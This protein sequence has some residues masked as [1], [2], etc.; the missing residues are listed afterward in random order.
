LARVL[1]L[2]HGMP[3][4]AGSPVV[5]QGLRAYANGQGL[6]S[7]GHEVLYCTRTEDLPAALADAPSGGT[8]QAKTKGSQAAK[9]RAASTQPLA[10]LGGVLGCSGNPYS[11]TET[12][13]LQAIINEVAPDVILV[14]SPEDVRRL[15]SG[16]F[17][18][19]L[20]LYAPRI[21]EAQYQDGTEER[22]AVRLFDAISRADHFIFSNERQRHFFLPLLALSGVDCTRAHGDVV[23]ISCPPTLPKRSATATKSGTASGVKFLAGGVFWPW[24]DLSDGL[25]ELIQILDKA[26]DGSVQLFGGKYGIRSETTRYLDPRNK[27]PASDRLEF[28]GIVPI[29]ELWDAYAGGSVAFD[30]MATGAERSINLS[31]RQI[32]YLR[33]GLPIITSPG[34]VIAADL[35]QYGAGWCV[36]PDDGAAL[37]TLVLRLLSEPKLIAKAS[38]NAQRLAAEKYAWTKTIAPLHRFVSDPR[39]KA[40][41]ETFLA[42]ITREQ[43]DLWEDREANKELRTR[44]ARFSSDLDKKTAEL[45]ARNRSAEEELGYWERERRT[46]RDES[47]EAIEFARVEKQAALIERDELKGTT[48]T[49]TAQVSLLQADVR[50][51]TQA[52]LKAQHAREALQSADAVRTQEIWAQANREVKKATRERGLAAEQEALAQARVEELEAELTAA[53]T[54][55]FKGQAERER[56]Q[57][58]TERRTQ[59]V[60]TQANSEVLKAQSET[61]DTED[62]LV[63]AKVRI[64]ELDTEVTGSKDNLFE[65][66]AQRERLREDSER[67]VQHVWTQANSEVLKAQ[68]ETSDVEDH[69]VKAQARM[70][71]LEDDVRRKTEALM[72]AE[73]ERERVQ[74]ESDQHLQEVW[75]TANAQTLAAQS[76]TQ[77]VRNELALR[78]ARIEE[79]EGELKAKAEALSASQQ[80]RDSAQQKAAQRIEGIWAEAEH[81]VSN[82]EQRFVEG[83][84]LAEERATNFLR[85]AEATALATSD[86]ILGEQGNITAQV[87][88][89]KFEVSVLGKEVKKKSRE[90]EEAQAQRD[91]ANLEKAA[92]ERFVAKESAP[93]PVPVIIGKESEVPEA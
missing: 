7:E 34:Q 65:S 5:G 24:A 49:L 33:C 73:R 51:K 75:R 50:K 54:A 84:A 22:D 53:K 69:L 17:A 6:S 76:E 89:L 16:D 19:V 62:R 38:K 41:S 43:A 77:D 52:L 86:V 35:L 28:S 23:P 3:P 1:I 2:F 9:A 46:L 58:E 88:E 12:P 85:E 14:E 29:D 60:W 32:D 36:D 91:A 78:L 30:L 37:R 10:T 26:K 93:E 72:T 56:L 92:L 48:D 63:Q 27:L 81:R 11:F 68:S 71:E 4:H 47:A 13:Q 15:P 45:A 87:E 18:V 67:R 42:R 64:E 61:S 66:Q 80:E 39:R 20:D 79:L 44:V 57:Q 55:F 8:K 40:H 90:L 70:S 74:Q 82:Q 25:R 31:F 21:L 59:Q 83:L